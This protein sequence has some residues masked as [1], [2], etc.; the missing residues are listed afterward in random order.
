M[1]VIQIFLGKTFTFGQTSGALTVKDTEVATG[2]FL[3]ERL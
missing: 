3:P 1:V 2:T